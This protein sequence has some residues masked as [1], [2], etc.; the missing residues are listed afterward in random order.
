[1][2]FF[3]S[4]GLIPDLYSRTPIQRGISNTSITWRRVQCQLT[5]DVKKTSS[6][7]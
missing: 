4:K 6:K 7:E 2:L 5:S 3:V 1:M